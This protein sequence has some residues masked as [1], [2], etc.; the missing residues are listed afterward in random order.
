MNSA[1]GQRH[2]FVAERA[3][4]CRITVL[5]PDG[6]EL[7]QWT[8]SG[9]GR[10]DLAAVDAL[11]QLQ[12]AASRQGGRLVVRELSPALAELLALAGLRREVVGETEEREDRL[13]VEEEVKPADPAV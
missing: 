10:P 8:L 13:G 2:P 6:D 11:A 1:R 7:E 12:L 9:P 5:G 3:P 4:W